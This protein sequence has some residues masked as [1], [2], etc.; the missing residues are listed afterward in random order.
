MRRRTGSRRRTPFWLFLPVLLLALLASLP[1]LYVA[2]KAWDAGWHSD[3]QL[4]W[5]PDVFRL[6][7]HTLGLMF[8]VTLLSAL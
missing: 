4:L 8:G 2:A 7:G 5:R 1:L 3:W 6:L